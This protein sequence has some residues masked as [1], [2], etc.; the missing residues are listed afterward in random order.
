MEHLSEYPVLV[1]HSEL[2]D[3][4][5]VGRAV[6]E[7]ASALAEEDLTVEFACTAA[8]VEFAVSRDVGIGAALLDPELFGDEA[9]DSAAV[10]YLGVFEEGDNR[11]RGFESEMRGIFPRAGADGRLRYFT[12]VVPQAVVGGA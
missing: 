4:S 5:A 8:D 9:A 10:A 1:A 7:L 11:F 3:G 6:S 12:Y 2:S